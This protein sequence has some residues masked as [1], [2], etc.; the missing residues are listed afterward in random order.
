MYRWAQREI[1]DKGR[2]C[3][4][5]SANCQRETGIA[6]SLDKKTGRDRE[7]HL[8]EA[9]NICVCGAGD[10][11]EVKGEDLFSY[12]FLL[13]KLGSENTVMFSVVCFVA[14]SSSL[15]PH[16][17]NASVNC[18]KLASVV[19][20]HIFVLIAFYWKGAVIDAVMLTKCKNN[21]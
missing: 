10:S 21:V 12:S 13:V 19:S 8:L 11:A 7:R 14:A 5:H 16:N 17:P 20:L 15:Y 4:A 18:V 1:L 2:Y 3:K 6:K 9:A